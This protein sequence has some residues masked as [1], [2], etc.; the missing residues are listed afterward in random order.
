MISSAKW[1]RRSQL[2]KILIP[3][4]SSKIVTIPFTIQTL[5]L[6]SHKAIISV[7]F[8]SAWNVVSCI[9]VFQA[10]RLGFSRLLSSGTFCNIFRYI[11]YIYQ[12]I[13]HDNPDEANL[14]KKYRCSYR[15]DRN[16]SK[17]E[18]Q[19]KSGSYT[20]RKFLISTGHR[21]LGQG[22]L[23]G[24]GED[25]QCTQNFDRKKHFFFFFFCC[26]HLEA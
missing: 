26:S 13:R 22:N 3:M 2:Q 4:F 1:K 15:A 16:I 14:K 5:T 7:G 6:M 18:G 19:S 24:D 11:L 9:E 21:V 25:G 20:S 23:V 8:L 10:S 17:S 12:I